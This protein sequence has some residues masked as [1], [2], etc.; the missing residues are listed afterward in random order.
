MTWIYVT[1]AGAVVVMT[2]VVARF[3]FTHTR[4]MTSHIDGQVV[5]AEEKVIIEN[6]RRRVETRVVVRYRVQ[7]RELSLTRTVD[8]AKL[9]AYPS[10][11]TIPIR[12]NPAEPEMADLA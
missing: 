6:D 2:A 7:G 5:S 11:R 10:G 4:R 8:G 1:V 3:Y 9:R 12:Y